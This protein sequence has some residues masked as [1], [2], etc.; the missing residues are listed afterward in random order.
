MISKIADA[1]ILRPEYQAQAR[2]STLRNPNASPIEHLRS[3]LTS[4][5][6]NG[7]TITSDLRA[8]ETYP[9][10]VQDLWMPAKEDKRLRSSAENTRDPNSNNRHTFIVD[11]H[12]TVVDGNRVKSI[13]NYARH[14][15]NSLLAIHAAPRTW[16]KVGLDVLQIYYTEMEAKFPELSLCADNWKAQKV[17]TLAYSDW[18]GTHVHAREKT[19]KA[20]EH[21]SSPVPPDENSS[22]LLVADGLQAMSSQSGP[23]GSRRSRAGIKVS[24]F[25]SSQSTISYTR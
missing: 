15:F 24:L 3:V 13:T 17:A 21:D 10:A 2:L 5:G 25:I 19:G 9:K 11:E 1:V 6:T 18:H 14:F 16:Q 4:N 7:S 20:L 12:G 23:T 22:Q 8:K